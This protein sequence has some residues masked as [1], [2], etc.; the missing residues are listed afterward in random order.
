MSF[1]KLM[2]YQVR[3]WILAPGALKVYLSLAI[4]AAILALLSSL[5][6]SLLP[7]KIYWCYGPLVGLSVVLFW[8]VLA[9]VWQ[10]NLRL[11]VGQQ[12][13]FTVAFRQIVMLLMG[14][15][16]PGKV[17]G[18]LA[19]GRDASVNEQLPATSSYAAAYLEQLISIHAGFL[20]GLSLLALAYPA[21]RWIAIS[22]LISMPSLILVP[23]FHHV[24]I[25]QL[26]GGWLKKYAE[27]LTAI[28]AIEI[29]LADYWRLFLAYVGEWI[30]T[31]LILVSVQMVITGSWPDGGLFM[32]LLGSY[33]VAMVVGFIAIFAPGGIGVREGVMV[34]LLAPVLGLE[35]ASLLAVVMRVVSVIA[36]L[37][38]GVI[39][40]VLLRRA[41]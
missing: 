16:L 8:L 18:V 21:E 6:L 26:I 36:D 37:V 7:E 9:W 3:L 13:G 41:D 17:W 10:L 30:V 31:G 33:A 34:A 19:R 29:S 32:L 22:F 40:V 24:L 14:K 28:D 15:Y 2:I 4:L 35:A 12:I 23:K 27:L 38:A 5:D 39:A 25:K 11:T 1:F 20:F